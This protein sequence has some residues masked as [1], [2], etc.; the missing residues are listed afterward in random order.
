MNAYFVKYQMLDRLQPHFKC[1]GV[2]FEYAIVK[3]ETPLRAEN[4]LS[5]QMAESHDPNRFA[6]RIN[7][8]IECY[9]TITFLPLKTEQN[10]IVD[11]RENIERNKEKEKEY[12]GVL[13]TALQ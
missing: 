9:D 5:I 13:W 4:I 1:V 6:I 10:T 8:T 11:N 2:P 3:A 12:Y 7:S